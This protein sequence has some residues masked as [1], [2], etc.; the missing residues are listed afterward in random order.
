MKFTVIEMQNG[1]IDARSWT[2]DTKE[3]AEVK[4]FQVLAEAVT[5]PIATHTVMLVNEEG[6][7]YECRYYIHG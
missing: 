3:A 5:S 4:L 1:V 7:V 6:L 2:Y